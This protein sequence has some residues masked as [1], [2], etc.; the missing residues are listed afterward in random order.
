[1]YAT[2]VL[3]YVEYFIFVQYKD[4]MALGLKNKNA[5]RER[6]FLPAQAAGLAQVAPM[7]AQKKNARHAARSRLKTAQGSAPPR[8]ELTSPA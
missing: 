7:T 8:P 4:D 5:A 2:I 3:T 1:M 6:D